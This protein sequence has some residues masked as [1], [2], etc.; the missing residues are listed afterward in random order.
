[1]LQN[2]WAINNW[3]QFAS[4]KKSIKTLGGIDIGLEFAYPNHQVDLLPYRVL[5]LN[6]FYMLTT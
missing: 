2:Y 3:E 1:M 6:L 5:Q 4:D